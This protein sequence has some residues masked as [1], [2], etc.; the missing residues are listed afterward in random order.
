LFI[1]HL[2]QTMERGHRK[3]WENVWNHNRIHE[4]G[5]QVAFRLNAHFGV[6][7][8][9]KCGF[10]CIKF[11]FYCK[12]WCEGILLRDS[13]KWLAI[14]ICMDLENLQ[15]KVERKQQS[16]EKDNTHKKTSSWTK[17][18]LDN[19]K[20]HIVHLEGFPTKAI[21][22]KRLQSSPYTKHAFH[23]FDKTFPTSY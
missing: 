13:T 10:V 2:C 6:K 4:R 5:Q 9:T 18:I 20:T 1:C 12:G 7:I 16:L 8:G 19:H 11:R 3:V 15:Q 21:I 23:H 17:N 22:S 14:K